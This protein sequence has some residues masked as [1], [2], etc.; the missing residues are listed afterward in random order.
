MA[1]TFMNINKNNWFMSVSFEFLIL[2]TLLSF[3]N[4]KNSLF[5]TVIILLFIESIMKYGSSPDILYRAT[6]P[7]LITIMIMLI[8][9]MKSYKFYIE[10]LKFSNYKKIILSCFLS[11]YILIAAVSPFWDIMC[12]LDNTVNAYTT[13]GEVEQPP[14]NPM[15]ENGEP[16]YYC[17]KLDTFFFKYIAN[18]KN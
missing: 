7:C 10:T 18:I 4:Y 9:T 5:Y 8:N 13:G 2:L 3:N 6:L 14:Q 11:M 17:A 15:S 12:S 1:I 16:R